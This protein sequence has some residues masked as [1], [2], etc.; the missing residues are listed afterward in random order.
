VESHGE[1]PESDSRDDG[2]SGLNRHKGLRLFGNS[3]VGSHK[4]ASAI[5][6][7][8]GSNNDRDCCTDR[9][10]NS[11]ALR[12]SCS[13]F[14]SCGPHLCLLRRSQVFSNWQYFNFHIAKNNR[15]KSVCTLFQRKLLNNQTVW[16][17]KPTIHPESC[18]ELVR[19]PDRRISIFVGVKSPGATA[20]VLQ[21]TGLRPAEMWAAKAWSCGRLH[22]RR[23]VR[24]ALL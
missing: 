19:V 7:S 18:R 6:Q 23:R 14:F 5:L 11:M 16:P 24:L 17:V 9:C 21:K 3:S 2:V 10:W 22:I 1:K 20:I 13:K 12:C 15:S 8:L 4:S